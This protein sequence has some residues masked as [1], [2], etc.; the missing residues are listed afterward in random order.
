MHF[1]LLSAICFNL[2]QSKI[3]SSGNGLI[4]FLIGRKHCGIR[5]KSV[6]HLVCHLQMISVSYLL[7]DKILEWCTLKAVSDD[8]WNMAEMMEFV[9]NSL[10]TDKIVDLYKLG[11]FAENK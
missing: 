5:G 7:Q 4:T 3:L 1:K 8:I 11:A 10:L 9:Y 2:Y 6:A